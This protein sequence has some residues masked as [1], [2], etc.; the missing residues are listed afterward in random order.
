[1]HPQASNLNYQRPL[2]LAITNGIKGKCPNCGEG[3][4]YQGFISVNAQCDHCGEELHHHQ[5]DDLPPYLNIFLVGHIMVALGMFSMTYEW[6]G[7]W[8]TTIGFSLLAL[9]LSLALIRPIKG[10]VVGLQWAHRMHGF[11][12]DDT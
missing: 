1:M 7:L 6:F 8:E 12:A 9:I 11:E 2:G 10:A 3:K 4:L 5:A